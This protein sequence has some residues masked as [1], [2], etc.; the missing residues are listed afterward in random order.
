M[1]STLK[2]IISDVE[3]AVTSGDGERRREML[4]KMTDLFTGEATR[5]S[6]TQVTAFDVVILRLAHDIETDARAEL[7]GRLAD[8]AN[9]PSNVVRDLAFDAS[10]EV[11]GPVLERSPRLS[12]DD[13][14]HVAE[15]RGQEHL[16]AMTR[17]SRLSVRVTDVLVGRGNSEV[18][19]SVAENDGAEF[20]QWGHQTLVGRAASDHV[21]RASLEKRPDIPPA[22]RKRLTV[23]AQEQAERALSAEFGPDAQLAVSEAV[24]RAAATMKAPVRDDALLA[25]EVAVSTQARKSE[26]DEKVVTELLRSGR[27]TEALVALARV[28]GVPSQIAL[29]AYEAESHEPLLCLVRAAKFGWRVLKLLISAKEGHPPSPETMDGVLKAFQTISITTAQRVLR[30]TAT[31]DHARHAA[32]GV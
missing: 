25:A 13:L 4:R 27:E 16:L 24:G 31:R 14:V 6:D 30:F 11:A 12:E 23:L 19:R 21:L 1:T 10:V 28:A 26:L 29:Q 8:I 9:A 17:R 7:S 20:S 3:A 2:S 32:A 22:Y 15:R 18:V 5:L